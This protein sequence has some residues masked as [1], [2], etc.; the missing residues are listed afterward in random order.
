MMDNAHNMSESENEEPGVNVND[1]DEL[2]RELSGLVAEEEDYLLQIEKQFAAEDIRGD[3][4]HPRVANLWKTAMETTASKEKIEETLKRQ[5]VPGNCDGMLV[6]LVN[7]EMWVKLSKSCK[8]T[9][10]NLQKLQ[11][12]VLYALIPV[13][14]LMSKCVESREGSITLNPNTCLP[15]LGD[16]LRLMSS[17]HLSLTRLRRSM[18]KPDL[19]SNY[20]ELCSGDYNVTS[21]MLFGDDL[22]GRIKEIGDLHRM[23]SRLNIEDNRVQT[24][25]RH[26]RFSS[27]SSRRDFTRKPF[28][29]KYQYQ[30]KPPYQPRW[31]QG[32]KSVHKKNNVT[33]H[34]NKQK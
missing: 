18:I 29:G 16:S 8:D 2:D 20:R 22:S 15:F 6:P 11:Q 14:K 26:R 17:A 27:G 25:S 28:L 10:S 13:L 19:H 21:P 5:L 33:K 1:N 31:E 30:N 7:K 3:N 34:Y 23:S 12:L 24:F 9:D 32:A 4:L